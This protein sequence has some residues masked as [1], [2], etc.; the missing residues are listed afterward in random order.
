M[1]YIILRMIS[2]G[3]VDSTRVFQLHCDSSCLEDAKSVK[4]NKPI[5][6]ND[7][8]SIGIKFKYECTI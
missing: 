8:L 3:R 5:L 7:V 2:S 1:Y 6:Y 4:A